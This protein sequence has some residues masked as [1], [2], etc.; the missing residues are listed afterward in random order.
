MVVPDGSGSLTLRRIGAVEVRD[1]SGSPRIEEARGG[2]RVEDG[3][4]GLRIEGVSGDVSI[5]EGSG[6]L[7]VSGVT[8]NVVVE[9]DGS[10]E[11]KSR[12]WAAACGSVIRAPAGS[13]CAP[14]KATSPF[15]GGRPSRID[16]ANIGGAVE[17]P[18][19]RRRRWNR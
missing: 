10:G 12:V 11:S 17:L 7:L 5:E 14:S 6:G 9:D 4:G 8:G 3:S 18:P 13:P 15:P 1:G 2:V 19:E 16:Y